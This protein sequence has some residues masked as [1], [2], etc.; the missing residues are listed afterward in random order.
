MSWSGGI[1][2]ASAAGAS[3]TFPSDTSDIFAYTKGIFTAPKAGLYRFELYGSKGKDA[4]SSGTWGEEWWSNA[5][6]G[7]GGYVSYYLEMSAGQT[8]YLL[9]LIHI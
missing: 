3:T 8:V 5:D 4:S 7:R 9:S 2:A 6:G 1:T